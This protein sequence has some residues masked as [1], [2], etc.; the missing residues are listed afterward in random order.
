MSKITL[1]TVSNIIGNETTALDTIKNNFSTIQTA[2]DNTLSRDG[3]TPNTMDSDFNLNN[4][5][6][7]NGGTATFT[8]LVVGGTT[9][10]GSTNLATLEVA[11]IAALRALT[12]GGFTGVF[13]TVLSYLS[14]KYRGGGLFKYDSTDTTSAD[15]GVTIFVD[16]S[17]RRW[18]R[19]HTPSPIPASYGG[20]T[21]D[22]TT[23]D[24]A[25][26]QGL[27]TYAQSNLNYGAVIDLEGRS[28]ALTDTLSI[29]SST[30]I[31]IQNGYLIAKTSA[32]WSAT[33]TSTDIP[34]LVNTNRCL[35]SKDFTS[36]SW[37]K[38]TMSTAQTQADIEGNANSATLLTATSANAT[39]TQSIA[40]TS[41]DVVTFSIF[42]KRVTG[43]GNIEM[44][45]DNGAT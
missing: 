10:T 29:T 32:N 44:T 20:A 1:D 42:M 4:N 41:G 18:K 7:L 19:V 38:T 26:L 28:Y 24:Y 34:G 22:G 14:N 6:I 31:I 25:A 16:A 30:G 23:D 3:T 36:G 17:S 12:T 33:Y 11:T 21:G 13:V 15:N 2:V 8:S 43:S 5:D 35:Q 9:I 40:I 39:V 37:T 27:I 45:V